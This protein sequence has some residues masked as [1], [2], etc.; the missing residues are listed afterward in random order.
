ME[1]VEIE[2]R[3][4]VGTTNVHYDV[5]VSKSCTVEEFTEV[6]ITFPP[7]RFARGAFKLIEEEKYEGGRLFDC[8]KKE[9]VY[10]SYQC[11]EMYGGHPMPKQYLKRNVL[12][13][14]AEGYG[15]GHHNP[16]IDYL[17]LLKKEVSY[18]ENKYGQLSLYKIEQ[19]KKK[20]KKS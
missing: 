5:E 2:K 17:L 9:D 7:N 15:L 19:I 11:A 10:A 12:K 3:T 4:R 8:E 14:E 6:V 18:Y 16:A 13:I 20:G 1:F